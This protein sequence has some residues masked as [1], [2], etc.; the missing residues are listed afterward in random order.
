[1]MSHIPRD[2]PATYEIHIDGCLSQDWSARLD[3]MMISI[4]D[5]ETHLMGELSDQSALLGILNTLVM[6]GFSLTFVR[7]LL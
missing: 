5:N 4:V 6:L 3:N 1:M 7:R 2:Q